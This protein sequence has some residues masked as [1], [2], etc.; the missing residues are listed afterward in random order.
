[1][2][3]VRSVE[4]AVAVLEFLARYG[5]SAA[6]GEIRVA[7]R[8]PKSTALNIVRTLVAKNML[9]V[10]ATTKQYKLGS[11]IHALASQSTQQFDVRGVARPY[12]ERVARATEEGVFLSTLD[13]LGIVYIDKIDSTQSVRFTAHV[14]TRRP[15]HCTSA[16][17]IALAASPPALLE[18]YLHEVGLPRYTPTTI[19]SAERL[20]E[21]LKRIRARGY[22]VGFSEYTPDLIAVAAPVTN[23]EGRFLGAVT[24]AGPAFRM[25][26]RMRFI[27]DTLLAATR[28]L[29]VECNG[30]PAAP[31]RS[32]GPSR[33]AAGELPRSVSRPPD[34][35]PARTA[36]LRPARRR[37]QASPA[38]PL[39]SRA[40]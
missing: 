3:Q 9:A 21:E 23:A 19:S 27:R 1:M 12:L 2:R 25:R 6:L 8:T 30:V 39:T 36:D 34:G 24:V 40:H 38:S 20:Q 31:T 35:G 29:T 28:A 14:G 10:D 22:A 26:R 18:R 15:L 4:R 11:L 13:D 37:R 5:R 17:K 33:R 7:I 32:V 16:G